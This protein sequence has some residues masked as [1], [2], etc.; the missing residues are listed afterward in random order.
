MARG[1]ARAELGRDS[2]RVGAHAEDRADWRR[3]GQLR[4]AGVAQRD[5]ALH[6]EALQQHEIVAAERAARVLVDHLRRAREEAQRV[7]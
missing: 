3:R 5:A 6:R 4:A 7:R 2:P 1:D